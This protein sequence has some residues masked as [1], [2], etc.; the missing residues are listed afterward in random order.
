MKVLVT[1]ADG[2]VG[3]WLTKAL[4]QAG[5]NVTAAIRPDGGTRHRVPGHVHTV[6]L[7]LTDAD[8][9]VRVGE[10]SWDAVIHLAA[11]A[12]GGEA[13]RD[14]GVA[15]EVNAVGTA[16]LAEVCGTQRRVGRAD[17]VFLLV[18]TAE[19]YGAGPPKPRAETD[20]PEPCSP[21]AASKLAAEV[22]ALEV[23]RRTGL[24]VVVARSFPHT[25]P[26]QDDRF[27]VP[28]F[29]RR[30]VAARR[31]AASEIK[32][33]SLEPVRELLHVADVVRAYI[34]LLE[35]GRAGETYN[36]ASG[37]GIGL[38]DLLDQMMDIVGHR[39]VPRTDATL[40]RAADIPHL[41]GDPGK[42]KAATGWTA[43]VPLEQTLQEV[44]D[45]QAS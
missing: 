8:S 37:A 13:R 16:R 7:E 25:G 39:V 29:A 24:R 45:A 3:S 42:L 19:V 40:L 4:L 43:T 20:S 10:P 31:A 34:L 32:V 6:A 12:S 38:R 18:S 30:L 26:G 5:H 41:V 2:F 21:Y 11:V 9:V 27:V 23:H 1:G 17:P 14:P 15:W 44:V 35:H 36:V 28:A 33:G 22:A